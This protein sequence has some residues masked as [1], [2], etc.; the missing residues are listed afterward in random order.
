MARVFGG[1]IEI[2]RYLTEQLNIFWTQ[3]QRTPTHLFVSQELF[4]AYAAGITTIRYDT[5]TGDTAEGPPGKM[6]LYKTTKMAPTVALK[7]WDVVFG[8]RQGKNE[9]T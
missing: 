7:D 3:Y 2:S 6:L 4:D 5:E 1:L 8:R 9:N